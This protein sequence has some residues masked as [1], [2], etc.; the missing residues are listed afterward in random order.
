MDLPLTLKALILGMVEGVTEFLPISSTAHLILAGQW[1]GF[2]G[3]GAKAFEVII[4]LGAI[5]AICWLFRARL[6]T[7]ARTLGSAESNRFILNLLLAFLPAALVGVLTH[8]WIK[9]HLFTPFTVALAML[10][11]GVAILAIEKN[12]PPATCDTLAAIPPRTALLIGMCQAL[13]LIPGV[14][15][16]GATIL[17]AL[18]LG[19]AR[20]VAAEF[21]FFLAIPVMCAATLFELVS[22][23]TALAAIGWEVLATGFIAAFF[24]ALVVVRWFITFIS[25]ADFT[26]FAWYRIVMGLALLAL[27]I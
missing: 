27:Y 1:I 11:G 9:A 3:E 20:P 2:E 23:H 16:S 24:S 22:N 4:Q 5:L 6:F 10:A 15:R 7:V 14:S 13:A 8:H 12:K 25:R 18:M 21:S 26:P 17:G 19:L